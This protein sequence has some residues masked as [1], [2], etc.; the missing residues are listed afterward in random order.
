MWTLNSLL[1][2]FPE[3]KIS[4]RKDTPI[5]GM[6][7]NSKSIKPGFLFLAKKGL[8]FDGSQYIKEAVLSG[9]KALISEIFDPSLP[10]EIAQVIVPCTKALEAPLAQRFYKNPSKKL[11]M[12]GITGTNGKTTTAYLCQH[13]LMAFKGPC[14]LIG[15]NAY[16]TGKQTITPT[17]TTPDVI[18][19]HKLLSEM[20]AHDQKAAVM[21]VTSHALDQGRVDCIDFDVAIFTNL[22]QDHLDYHKTMDHYRESK[23]KLFSSLNPQS[24]VLINGDD[25]LAEKMV[26][27]CSAD[28]FTYGCTQ[29]CSLQAQD[30]CY[31]SAFTTCNLLYNNQ[32]FP[33]K[34]P[35]IGGFNLY[36]SLA[37]VALGIV[38]KTPIEKI[39]KQFLSVKQI[40]GRME[41]VENTLDHSV[42]IDFAH[43]PDALSQV[44]FTLRDCTKGKLIV[45]FG[46]GGDRD[47]FKRPLMG[48]IAEKGADYIILT[49]DNPR[50]EPPLEILNQ[51]ACG[52]RDKNKYTIEEDR[53]LAIKKGI[54]LLKENKNNT[55][56]IAGKGHEKQQIF[57]H[58]TVAFSDKDT[59]LKIIENL[60][61]YAS[62]S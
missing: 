30:I 37:A 6:S 16:Y 39:L 32:L 14:G 1:T 47:P 49:S 46:C 41:K 42:F 34:T 38:I 53:T 44:L 23:E 18:T 17:H 33:F 24:I 40:E 61:C 9:A 5:R 56:L 8:T 27:N 59:V 19:N 28:I 7:S 50:S 2:P 58:K 31:T 20:V 15:T 22:T 29:S 4:G 13:I 57:S 45:V 10:K 26:K 43:T 21:E 55:L 60:S 62:I 11:F 12:V 48:E 35:L 3:K 52:I 36:N 54:I 25:P 51:I